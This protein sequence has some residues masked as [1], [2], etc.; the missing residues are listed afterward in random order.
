MALAQ[1]LAL[2]RVY[3][4]RAV[5]LFLLAQAQELE[6]DVEQEREQAHSDEVLVLVLVCLVAVHSVAVCELVVAHAVPL[7]VQLVFLQGVQDQELVHFEYHLV[8]FPMLVP[9]DVC[10]LVVRSVVLFQELLVL[11]SLGVVVYVPPDLHSE[12]VE[13]LVLIPLYS[14][15]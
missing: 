10:Q 2:A 15:F 11:A 9:L 8:F 6:Q 13:Q 4:A 7:S 5:V 12:Q 1:A 3:L 14:D